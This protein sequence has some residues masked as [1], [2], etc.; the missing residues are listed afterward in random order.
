MNARK[1]RLGC[2]QYATQASG[3]LN[4]SIQDNVLKLCMQVTFVMASIGA[5]NS[6][7]KC[8][9]LLGGIIGF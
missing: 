4:K 6:E 7:L 8:S 5:E 9:F 3:R 1:V 2:F